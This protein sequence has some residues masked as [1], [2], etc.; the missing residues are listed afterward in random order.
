VKKPS[1]PAR[2]PV[3]TAPGALL[4]RCRQLPTALSPLGQVSS[5]RPRR[6]GRAPVNHGAMNE[7]LHVRRAGADDLELILAMIAEAAAWLPAKGTNQWS[8]PWP[9]ESARDARVLRGLRGGHTWIAE[10]RDAPVATITYR[11]YGS[12]TLWSQS[13]RDEPAVYV[14]RLIVTR[15]AAG[16]E[17]GA[18]MIDWAG[19]R[20]AR[21]WGAQ[22]VRI[23]VWTTNVALHDYFEKR[24][25]RYCRTCPFGPETYP[26]AALFQKPTTEVDGVAAS[27]FAE[28]SVPSPGMDSTVSAPAR[29]GC[30]TS[31]APG[32]D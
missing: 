21:G 13:E 22:W 26:S 32:S 28:V 20:A 4:S 5:S 6:V 1:W 16:R 9:S 31:P 3:T 11:Q 18:A 15:A 19:Q 30:P 27:R 29:L 17:I 12:Q 24:G 14:S 23:D 10:Q 7:I 2:S 8:T 25:F